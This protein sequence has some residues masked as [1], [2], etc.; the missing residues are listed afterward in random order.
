MSKEL[1]NFIIKHNDDWEEILSKDP[2]NLKITRDN[3]YVMFKY[4]QI[5][6]DFSSSIVREARG[7]IFREDSWLCVRRAFDKFFNYG[8]TNSATINWNNATV[9]EKIDGSLVSAWYDNGSWHYSTNGTIDMFKANT[10]DI[11]FPTFGDIFLEALR[12]NNL[13]FYA[14]E[15]YMCRDFCYTFELVSPQ[16]RV[17]IPYSKADLYF[18][19]MRDMRD[20]QEFPANKESSILA[21]L[22]KTPKMYNFI[23]ENGNLNVELLKA[24]AAALPWDEEGYVVVDNEFNR[25][26]VKSISWLNAHYARNNSCISTERLIDI[27]L[28][29]EQEEFLVYA[30]DYKEELNKIENIMKEILSKMTA[31][32]DYINMLEFESRKD[33]AMFVLTF[34]KYVQQYLFSDPKVNA[35][36]WAREHWTA[37]K[38]NDII[39]SY[40]GSM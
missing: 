1:Y 27:I 31:A 37:K 25:V 34:P 28:S 29:G 15:E 18:I 40:K 8:E 16:T 23:D 19:G 6:S 26:K 10:N 12:N 32:A 13:D 9:L 36:H 4:N 22:L 7:I 11:K 33:Y 35:E 3:G 17:V 20:E 30:S 5:Y 14:L 38:W 24:T 21:Y 39:Q 2:Y